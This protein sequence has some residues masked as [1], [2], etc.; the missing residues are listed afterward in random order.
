MSAENERLNL[1]LTLG[2]FAEAEKY[3]RECI[4]RTPDWGIAYTQL[5]RA[6]AGLRRHAE[7]VEA[8]R[9]GVRKAPRDAWALAI[10][11]YTLKHA[12]RLPDAAEALTDAARADPTYT[13][14]YCMLAEVELDR[15]RPKEAYQATLNGVRHD[16]T[17][18]NLLRWKAWC[19]YQL[20]KLTDAVTTAESGLASHPNSPLLR[21]VLGCVRWHQGEQAFWPWRKVRLHHQ[22]DEYLT[23]AVR[24][25]PSEDVYRNNLTRNAKVCR[26]FV[27][28]W[29]V[30]LCLVVPVVAAVAVIVGFGDF[31]SVG[32]VVTVLAFAA[33]ILGGFGLSD[34]IVRAAPLSWCGV[35]SPPLAQDERHRGRRKLRWFVVAYAVWLAAAVLTGMATAGAF[36][37][38]K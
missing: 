14:T 26:K 33:A 28:A 15:S 16:P 22:A 9:E 19:E 17:A 2:R 38:F 31:E 12:G 1:L 25:N 37:P 20:D 34:D 5:G 23:E 4:G 24:L 11:G 10:L 30:G 21:N 32:G 13:W 3:A 36:G 7:A 27:A 29:G 6:L 18:E 8:A 35:P